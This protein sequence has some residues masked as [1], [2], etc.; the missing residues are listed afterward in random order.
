LLFFFKKKALIS[1]FV[2]TV[3]CPNPIQACPSLFCPRNC[4]NDEF[5]GVC[6]YVSGTCGCPHTPFYEVLPELC[7]NSVNI[8]VFGHFES[9]VLYIQSSSSLES[10]DKGIFDFTKRMFIQMTAGEVIGFV[11]TS[12]VTIG[13]CFII[14]SCCYRCLK[15]RGLHCALATFGDNEWRVDTKWQEIVS[16]RIG[17]IASR[18]SNKDKMVASVLHNMRVESTFSNSQSYQL[19]GESNERIFFRSEMP[20][21]AGAGRI[22][23]IV[24]AKFVDDSI[25]PSESD[26]MLTVDGT[27][28]DVG[29]SDGQELNSCTA[30]N[31]C[32]DG[33]S[34]DARS[35]DQPFSLSQTRR[36][37]RGL[38][39]Q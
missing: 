32:I 5:V 4:L 17:S 12:V 34:V 15:Q 26:D 7:D 13:A 35:V 9:T 10:D 20:P 38:Q 16:S 30:M 6:D 21:L 2:N 19:S 22:V 27:V 3:I 14:I 11:A 39:N 18:R 28:L 33:D 1:S 24:G 25:L 29:A 31:E 23:T 36:R 8:S 37:F